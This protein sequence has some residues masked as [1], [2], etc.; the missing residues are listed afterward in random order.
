MIDSDEKILIARCRQGDRDAFDTLIHKYEKKI[1]NLAYRLS[2]NYDEAS[3]IS[4]DVFLRIFQSI[5]QFRG[6]SNFTTWLYRVAT[7]VYLD[8]R[9]KMKNRQHVSLEEYIELDES[10]VVRQIEDPAPLP[11]EQMEGKERQKLL[12]EAINSLPEYQKVM[13]LLYHTEG[14]SYEEIAEAMS[15][16]IGTVKSRLNRARLSLRQ[17]L[18]PIRELF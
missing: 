7:N 14:L 15:M 3:D 4:V 9:K 1:Y 6:D 17:K 2:G 13:V 16:P 11:Q 18:E 8:R 5:H 12:L 10:S